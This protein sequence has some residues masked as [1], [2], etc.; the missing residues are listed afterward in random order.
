MG[1]P[2]RCVSSQLQ[3]DYEAMSDGYNVTGCLSADMDA[4][5]D[6]DA[7]TTASDEC[8]ACIEVSEAELA[9]KV[10]RSC[11]PELDTT[12]CNDDLNSTECRACV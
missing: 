10:L 8:L 3:I 2:R 12:A 9:A 7:N 6:D 1:L 11:T 5:E 4:L